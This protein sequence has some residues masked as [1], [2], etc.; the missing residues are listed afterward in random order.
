MRWTMTVVVV[1]TAMGVARTGSASSSQ[2]TTTELVARKLGHRAEIFQL[3]K[4]R[5]PTSFEEFLGEE[6]VPTD[7]WGR[8]FVLVPAAAEG[9]PCEIVSWGEDGVPGTT[10]TACRGTRGEDI[11]AAVPPPEGAP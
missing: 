2:S 4:K 3:R 5:A 9:E 6:P 1:V 8:P 11:R 10:T 7:G